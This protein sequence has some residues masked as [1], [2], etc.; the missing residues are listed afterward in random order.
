MIWFLS[1]IIFGLLC[2]IFVLGYNFSNAIENYKKLEVSLNES[3]LKRETNLI[4]Y[5]NLY[6]IYEK[7]IES[8]RAK[9]EK[10]QSL[11]QSFNQQKIN[12]QDILGKYSELERLNRINL[13]RI[14]S[15]H[16]QIT[17]EA[18][19]K[20]KEIRAARVESNTSQRAILRGKLNEEIAPLLPGWKYN[21]SDCRFYGAPVDFLILRGLS[22]DNITELIFL[23]VKSSNAQLTAR[24][25]QIRDCIENKKVSWDTFRIE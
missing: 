12:T 7:Q 2:S 11:V 19:E 8:A 5:S 16:K 24:Q 23:D 15:L 25:R 10:Y 21:F 1:F 22:E 3:L 6:K 4:D 17:N 18:A 13:L 9:D 20:D 14:E